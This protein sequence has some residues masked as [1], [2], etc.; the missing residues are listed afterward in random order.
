MFYLNITLEHK[1]DKMREN[2]ARC[3][4]ESRLQERFKLE[5][6]LAESDIYPLLLLGEIKWLKQML[7]WKS[8]LPVHTHSFSEK[9]SPRKKFDKSFSFGDLKI[10][11]FAFGLKAKLLWEK[12][13]DLNK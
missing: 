11:K 10:F 8:A 12:L 6:I 2:T 13:R 3:L 7:R 5:A 1:V 9:S 4:S